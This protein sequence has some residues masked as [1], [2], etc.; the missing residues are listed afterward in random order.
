MLQRLFIFAA[1]V[2]ILGVPWL[3]RPFSGREG[4]PAAR[5]IVVLT[6]HVPQIQREFAGAFDRWHRRVH[7]EG[8]RI[9]WRQPGGTSEIMKVL[10]A[11]YLSAAKAGSFDF[12]DPAN[13]SCA[14][15]T[16]AYD[17]MMGGGSFE[18]GKLKQGV[19]VT[20]VRLPSGQLGEATIPISIPGAFEQ[21]TLDEWY[22]ENAIGSAQLYDPQQH[23]YGTALSGFGIVYN[24]RAFGVLGLPEPTAFHDL[25]DPRLVGNLA[26]ADPRQS[27]SVTTTYDSILSNYGWDRGWALLREMSGNARYF[28]NSSP[29]PPI[30]VSHGEAA[31]GLAIDFYGRGQGQAVMRPGENPATSR[32]GYV[33]PQ[34]ATFIDAD[35]VAMLRGGPNPVIAKRFVEFCLSDEAQALWQFRALEID[36]RPNPAAEGNPVGADGERMG[37]RN[38]ALRRMPV[39]RE[40]YARY[41]EHFIDRVDPFSVASNTAPAG[42]RSAI[43]IMM[44]AF[45]IDNAEECRGAWRALNACRGTPVHEEA[46]AAFY[47]FPPTTLPDGT[48]LEFTAANFG[49][50]SA[51]WKNPGFRARC[52]VEYTRFY[53]ESYLR[54]E[55]L[56]TGRE[57]ASR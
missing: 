21:R 30:D 52:E 8:V 25:G 23:W 41:A 26:L 32:V 24:R 13:P 29:K 39:K 27:G 44:G 17:L 55:K 9:D 35:P 14:V 3:M 57:P 47:A 54:V 6:P 36:G 1:L 56:A 28:A 19:K 53:R 49:K 20:G 37:P 51:A 15:G 5:T 48:V 38:Y 31:A 22:G 11:H 43:P 2:A 45:G 10:E 50:I 46:R 4:Q 33:D 7:G 40:F 16:T 18:F 42:W 12:T 34:G